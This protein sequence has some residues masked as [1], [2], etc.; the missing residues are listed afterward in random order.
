MKNARDDPDVFGRLLF[1]PDLIRA[2]RPDSLPPLV[3]FLVRVAHLVAHEVRDLAVFVER[4]RGR[5][6]NADELQ[7]RSHGPPYLSANMKPPALIAG[8]ESRS[9][10]VSAC[11]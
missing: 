7:P 4:A 10:N 1:G 6:R 8:S 5:F 2:H 3:Q 9:R 11:F